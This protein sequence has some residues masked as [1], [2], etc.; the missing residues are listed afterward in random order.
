V[1]EQYGA[2]SKQWVSAQC[3]LGNLLINA[4]QLARAVQCYRDAVSVAP[5]NDPA[6]RRAHLTYRSNLGLAL[7][8]AGHLEEAEAQL[9]AGAAARV[10]S[11]GRA[12]AGCAC[13]RAPLAGVLLRR[14]AA[15]RPR[16]VAEEAAAT[17]WPNRHEKV[18]SVLALR[19][20]VVLADGSGA[21]VFPDLRG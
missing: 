9:R 21:E 2:G 4:D 14:G 12:R 10:H 8:M 5:G 6:F 3:D 20:E 15:A 18:A 11:R 1:T 19:A 13:G 7:R 16:G 17:R